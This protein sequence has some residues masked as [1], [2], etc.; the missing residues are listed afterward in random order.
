MENI[1]E[2]NSN[3]FVVER[4]NDIIGKLNEAFEINDVERA[5]KHLRA[6]Y[7]EILPKLRQNEK[8]VYLKLCAAITKA[9]AVP[10]DAGIITGSI[11]MG[12]IL[13]ELEQVDMEL[14]YL[15]DRHGLLMTNKEDPR[16]AALK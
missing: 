2:F 6:L 3:K 10:R 15:A 4:V 8:A 5:V 9:Q 1:S 14:R 11:S 12:K 16:V 7:K 13:F